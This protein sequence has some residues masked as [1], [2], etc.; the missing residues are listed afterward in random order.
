MRAAV[1]GAL[2]GPGATRAGLQRAAERGYAVHSSAERAGK[3][4]HALVRQ[5]NAPKG[6]A[7]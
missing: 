3:M 1:I 5:A 4:A 2:P 6:I 7:P